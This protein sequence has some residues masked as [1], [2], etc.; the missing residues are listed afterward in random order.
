MKIDRFLKL[1]PKNLF[2]KNF[3][4]YGVYFP[5]QVAILM[6]RSR[7]RKILKIFLSVNNKFK[8][9]YKNIYSK[10]YQGYYAQIRKF[11]PQK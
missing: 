4:F 3:K 9:N 11:K 5:N 6:W 7:F 8:Y 2:F 10:F 1:K